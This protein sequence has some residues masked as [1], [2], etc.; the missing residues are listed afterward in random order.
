MRVLKQ[1]IDTEL[2]VVITLPFYYQISGQ[3]YQAGTGL[4]ERVDTRPRREGE[5]RQANRR[6]FDRR[7]RGDK[8]YVQN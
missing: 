4:A 6:T 8:I 2:K 3:V 5:V 1:E 7:Y